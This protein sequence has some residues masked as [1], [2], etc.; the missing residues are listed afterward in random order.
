[1]DV[2][3]MKEILKKEYGIRSEN[4]FNIAVSKSAGINLGIFTIPLMKNNRICGRDE[5][6]MGGYSCRQLKSETCLH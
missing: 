4:E 2:A 5:N 3:K 6:K 1:M